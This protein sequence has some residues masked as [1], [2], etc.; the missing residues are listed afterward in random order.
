MV[1]CYSRWLRYSIRTVVK[2]WEGV[3]GDGLGERVGWGWFG[4]GFSCV[5]VLR[6]GRGGEG[7]REE[8]DDSTGSIL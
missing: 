2:G 8:K 1:V 3:F 7:E 5:C 6:G 4:G